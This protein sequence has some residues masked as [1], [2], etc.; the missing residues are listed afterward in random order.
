MLWA[1]LVV[2]MCAVAASHGAKG[3]GV[4]IFEIHALDDGNVGQSNPAATLDFLIVITSSI[5][6]WRV[7]QSKMKNSK[8]QKVWMP[9]STAPPCSA[10]SLN[11]NKNFQ[12]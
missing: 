3:S 10:L 2:N 12:V 8:D 4:D 7:L 1:L 11:G 5:L 9:K 6:V